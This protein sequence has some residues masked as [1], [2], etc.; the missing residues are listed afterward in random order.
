MTFRKNNIMRGLA[1]IAAVPSA[2]FDFNQFFNFNNLLTGWNLQG[3]L[4]GIVILVINIFITVL[5]VVEQVLR[6][7]VGFIK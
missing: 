2:S 1:A 7:V 3:G 4:R 5:S 6:T